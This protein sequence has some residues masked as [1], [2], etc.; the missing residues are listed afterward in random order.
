MVAKYPMRYEIFQS[1]RHN[2]ETDSSACRC[3]IDTGVYDFDRLLSREPNPP[4]LTRPL[5]IN[6]RD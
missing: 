4:L 5:L 3:S 6:T 2:Y 1:R